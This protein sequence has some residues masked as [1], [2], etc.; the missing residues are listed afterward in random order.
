[1]SA[2]SSIARPPL[3]WA[4]ASEV[5]RDLA[6]ARRHRVVLVDDNHHHR[7]PLL[8]ALRAEGHSVLHA[9]DGPS[10]EL[11]CRES[12]L[13]I[14]ALIVC[15]DMKRMGGFEL[16]RRARLLCPEV[17]VLL[18]SRLL[19]SEEAHRACDRGYAVIEEPFTAEQLCHR[20]TV[21]LG[22]PYKDAWTEPKDAWTE[23]RP[24]GEARSVAREK[25]AP[26]IRTQEEA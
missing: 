25:G 12:K 23:P 15:A 21:L 16:A 20:L 8:R 22:S 19:G 10:G 3:L 9:A 14:D 4:N 7:A 18:M 6:L 5:L 11:R 13:E 17:R 1:M 24:D 26:V 2:G